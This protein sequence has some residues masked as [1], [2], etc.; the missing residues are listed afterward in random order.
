MRRVFLLMALFAASACGMGVKEN[1]LAIPAR[2]Q[3]EERAVDGKAMASIAFGAAISKIPTG[4]IVVRY[5]EGMYKE[6]DDEYVGDEN[7]NCNTSFDYGYD[8]WDGGK[9]TYAGWSEDLPQIFYDKALALGFNVKGNPSDVFE[10]EKQLLAVNFKIAAELRTLKANICME[11]YFGQPINSYLGETYI[12]VRWVVYERAT[13]KVVARFDSYGF[14]EKTDE[15]VPT[16]RRLLLNMAFADAVAHLAGEPGFIALLTNADAE[17]SRLQSVDLN[18]KLIISG[19]KKSKKTIAELSPAYPR[20]VVTLRSGMGHGTGFIISRDGHILTAEHVVGEAKTLTV[21]FDNGLELPAEVL[22]VN[23]YRDAALLKVTANGLT[24]VALELDGI[25]GPL[26]EVYAIGSPLK[27]D[28]QTTF[29]R[30]VVSSVRERNTRNNLLFIQSD[31]A[32]QGGNSGGP[33]IDKYGNV[34]GIAVSGYGVE[35]MNAGLN[36]FVPINDALKY[37]NIEVRQGEAAK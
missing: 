32:I 20:S 33:L 21:K 5:P 9:N 2:P 4:E 16:G 28:L 19:V 30:G 3:A 1:S 34:V 18:E 22:R 23:A 31:V 24:P 27:E 6:Q 26:D 14:A 17:K 8:D 36:F 11:H 12:E 7:H 13:Q 37:L 35:Q 15:G 29:T 10:R 25:P